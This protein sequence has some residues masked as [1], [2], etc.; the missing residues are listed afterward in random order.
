M[1][2]S[3]ALVAQANK[4]FDMTEVIGNY[5]LNAVPRNLMTSDGKLYPGHSTKHKLAE[6]LTINYTKYVIDANIV[7]AFSSKVIVVDAMVLVQTGNQM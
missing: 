1:F 3:C 4:D 6:A 5:E 2:Y 7:N